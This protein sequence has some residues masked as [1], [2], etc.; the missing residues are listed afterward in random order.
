M[1]K[2]FE[3][4]TKIAR[5]I[6]LGN[7][8]EAPSEGEWG[9]KILP[10]YFKIIKDAGFTSVRIPIRWSSHVSDK[11]SFKIK[12]EFFARIDDVI[13]QA[14]ENNLIVIINIHHFNELYKNPFK[15]EKGFYLLWEQIG[16]RYKNYSQ[17]LL[18]EVLNEPHYFLTPRIWNGLL[19]NVIPIIRNKNR[20]RVLLVGPAKWN[21]IEGFRKFI[22]PDNVDNIIVTFH[23]YKPFVFTH[24]EAEWVK[25]SKFF[26]GKLWDASDKEILKI[27]KHF[28]KIK[29][30]GIENNFPINLGEFGAYH[31]ADMKSRIKWNQ[32]IVNTA[33]KNNFSYIYWEFGAGFGVFDIVKNEWKLDLLKSIF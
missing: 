22:I 30:W 3:L 12:N 15:Y 5:G 4:N 19:K 7:A 32:T 21:N 24:Q 13:N 20:D 14:L 16:G 25:F 18:F 2:S 6:S 17:N 26:R 28:S 9:L 27:E 23:Y 29:K 11:I 10:E 8:L 1:L 31:K 33:K